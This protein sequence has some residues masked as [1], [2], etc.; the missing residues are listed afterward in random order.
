MHKITSCVC[1]AY[2][3]IRAMR[4]NGVRTISSSTKH[5][6][7]PFIADAYKQQMFSC[8]ILV[9]VCTCIQIEK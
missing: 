3:S 1:Q 9:R 4:I 7:G 8:R 2:K 5:S 6:C